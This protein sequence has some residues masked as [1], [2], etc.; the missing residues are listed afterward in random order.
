MQ[1]LEIEE[2]IYGEKDNNSKVESLFWL[3]TVHGCL[4]EALKAANYLEKSVEM[5]LRLT[6]NQDLDDTAK[7]LY[8]LGEEFLK[9]NKI[10]KG[11]E[12]LMRA[13]DMYVRM[14]SEDKEKIGHC[15]IYL[16][17]AY[18]VLDEFDKSLKYFKKAYSVCRDLKDLYA[19]AGIL[20]KIGKEYLRRDDA[21]KALFYL[22]QSYAS[23]NEFNN[24][25]ADLDTAE[26]LK[27]MSEAHL[28]LGD[29]AQASVLWKDAKDMS[30]VVSNRIMK[31]NNNLD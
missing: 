4:G 10:P 5:K 22:R 30:R 2:K 28:K 12:F 23:Y 17:K 1:N 15:L 11:I 31:N 25:R 13:M 26:V 21:Q 9:L 27:K 18:Q 14:N 7:Q 16:G 3:G 20:H 19:V 8:I 24:G 29:S 6:G